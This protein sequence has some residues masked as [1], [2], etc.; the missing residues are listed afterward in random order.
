M[1]R[2]FVLLPILI[3]F[4]TGLPPGGLS[5]ATNYVFEAVSPKAQAA[6]DTVVIVRLI[7]RNTG[8]PVENAVIFQSRLDMSPD[9]MPDMTATLSP[10]PTQH[11]GEYRF[12]TYLSAGGRW[13]LK[14]AAEVPGEPETVRGE[15]VILATP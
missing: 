3:A 10:L 9:A 11:A 8:K 15:V 6:R 12:R 2:I 7:D 5:A 1:R 13:A 14:L 4:A